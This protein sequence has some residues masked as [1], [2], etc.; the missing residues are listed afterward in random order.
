MI[1]GRRPP[2]LAR[3]AGRRRH[4]RDPGWRSSSAR[5]W[6][7]SAVYLLVARLFGSP[8]GGVTAAV[9]FAADWPFAVDALSGPERQDPR[10]CCSRCVSM[11]LLARRRWFWGGLARRAGVAGV[12]ADG[13]LPAGRR[14]AAA[15]RRDRPAAVAPSCRRVAGRGDPGGADRRLLRRGGRVAR[16]S[17]RRPWSS[18]WP[19]SSAAAETVGA[20]LLRIRGVVDRNYGLGGAAV[21][22]R[23]RP[24]AGVRG[25]PPGAGRASGA[26]RC[27]PRWWRSSW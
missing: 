22:G 6:R 23:A 17:S 1:A 18:R 12:A 14:A 3:L 8:L 15:A 16:T 11:W 4:L 21:L 13:R 27:W 7:C 9:V 20:R 26:R 25:R 10:R 5:C 2:S 24:A 19:V